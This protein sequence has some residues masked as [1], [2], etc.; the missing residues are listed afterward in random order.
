VNGALQVKFH[1]RAQTEATKVGSKDVRVSLTYAQG[2][3]Y[4]VAILH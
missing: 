2:V 3:A 4:A 1:G